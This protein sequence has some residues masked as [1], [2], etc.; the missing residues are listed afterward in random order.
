MLEAKARRWR[1]EDCHEREQEEIR[2]RGR[3][4]TDDAMDVDADDAKVKESWEGE[5][6]E[7]DSEEV[8]ALKVRIL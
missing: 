3:R 1:D 6:D 4:W 2:R 7:D 5:D 8:P